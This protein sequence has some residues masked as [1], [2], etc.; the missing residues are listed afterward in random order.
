MVL[1]A[2]SRQV[3]R[4]FDIG[5]AKPS[6]AERQ[7]VLHRLI[8]ICDPTET[9]TVAEYQRLVQH[10][11][12][13]IHTQAAAIPLL[14]GGTGLYIDA[15]TK[16]LRI[17]PV[18]PQPELRSQLQALDQPQ[19]YAWLQQL[20]PTA[21]ARIHPHDKV[22]TLRALEVYYVTGQPISAQQGSQP[23]PYPILSIGL[24]CQPP[25]RLRTRIAQ[26]T[27]QMIEQGFVDEVKRL[28][29]QYGSDHPLLKTLGYA[30]MQ[31]YIA[32]AIGLADAIALTIQHTC[33]F[34]KRQRTWF[35][36]IPQTE[37]FDPNSENLTET[38]WTR[39]ETFL[40]AEYKN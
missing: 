20:D 39:V 36:K 32:G 28:S 7:Q 34:A 14:V 24:D 22:R 13:Q 19:I 23:P 25:E 15:V 18:P 10:E 2:D 9:L 26:R 37:W 27:Q 38:V 3:Y 16:G 40:K 35:R 6:P 21:A 31:H 5:T 29:A 8:D 17:P 12:S 33:Q 30:E 11:I 4:G 1:S